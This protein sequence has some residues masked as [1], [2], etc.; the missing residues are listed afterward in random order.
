MAVATGP[1]AVGTV[2][3]WAGTVRATASQQGLREVWLPRWGEA[4]VRTDSAEPEAK[5]R[6][7]RAPSHAAEEQLRM[8]LG[9]LAEY[10]AGKRRVFTVTLDLQGTDFYRRVWTEVAQIPWGET[11]TYQEVARQVGVPEGPRAV[12]AANGANAV[13]PFVP[14]HRVLGSDG[15]LTGY[16]PGLPLKQALLL[17]EDAL[18]AGADDYAAWGGRITGRVRAEGTAR[19]SPGLRR[20]GTFC[21]P[22]CQRGGSR[23]YVPNR[24]LRSADGALAAGFHPCTACQPAP[25]SM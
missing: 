21:R 4:T 17:P 10:F 12:G 5:V 16:G 25:T 24:L 1:L 13:A 18:P 23:R 11:R 9:E 6:I 3:T 2:A 8:A 7:E 19:W 22:A 15:R 14:C 20:L